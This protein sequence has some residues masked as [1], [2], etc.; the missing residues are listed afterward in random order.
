MRIIVSGLIGQYPNVG[1]TVWDYLQYAIGFRDL[2]HEVWYLEDTGSWC[3]N[4]VTE[5]H[6]ADCAVNVAYVEKMAHAFG[7]GDHWLYRN[8]ADGRWFGARDERSAEQILREADVLVNVAGSAWL[9]ESTAAIPHKL[10]LDGDPMFTHIKLSRASEKNR[11]RFDQH[12]DFFTFGLSIGQ[13]DCLAP[14][15][16]Y[17]WKT[18][19]QPVVLEL[20]QGEGT[21][22]KP[23]SGAWTTAMNWIS[24]DPQEFNGHTYGQKDSEFVKF[25]ELPRHTPETFVL[26]MGQGF[27]QKRPTDSILENGWRIVEPDK[28]IPDH[29]SY[30]QFLLDSKAEWSIAK[31]GYVAGRTGWFSCRTACYL[32]AGR[33]AVV[34]DTGWSRHLPSGR[35]AHAF[36]TLEEARRGIALVVQNYAAESAAAKKFA[37][38][39]FEAKKVCSKILEDS[40]IP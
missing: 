37:T 9:R 32:A 13:P 40:E 24:Y 30:R 29:E 17:D 36:A 23:W 11:Q 35:G 15:L 20:W 2:G 31:N 8:E 33:P 38:E 28:V 19:V 7:L 27:G 39:Y 21:A 25:L 12:T 14:V 5:E 1:G 26:A 18:T 4:P 22:G 10:Y 3:Y 16:G 34:Q 6:S